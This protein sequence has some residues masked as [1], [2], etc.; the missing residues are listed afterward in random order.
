[1]STGAVAAALGLAALAGAQ[2]RVVD[3]G[4]G[5][6]LTLV[7]V[8][9]G[10]F[11]M[12]APAEESPLDPDE[13]PPFP[14]R[15]GKAFELGKYEITNAQYA[16]FDP[17]HD[18]GWIDTHGKD[19]VG[20]G[21]PMNGPNQPVAR[22]SCLETER[23]CAWLG[24]RLGKACR[25]PTEAEWEYACRAGTQTPFSCGEGADLGQFANSADANLGGLKPW[26]V[27]DNSRND[28]AAASA[29]AGRYQPNAWGLHDMHGNV[30]EWTASA[31]RA[32]PYD[33]ADGRERPGPTDERVVRGGSWDDLPRRCRSAFRLSY[34][35]DQPV[36]N[37]GF[38]V[39]VEP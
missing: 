17:T 12:G 19:R 30:A 20:P 18:T 36:Y 32:Y 38:R 21:V 16:L 26:S 11:T 1:M 6:T 2:E 15:I 35:P 14:V 31:Y 25:L 23:F 29:D 22:V 24:E 10:E 5:V 37:V 4:D 27:R 39:V 8:P 9:A 34:Q 33:A 28:G 3:L 13:S 7:A